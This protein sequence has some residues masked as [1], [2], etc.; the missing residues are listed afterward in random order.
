MFHEKNSK[1]R[2]LWLGLSVALAVI[3]LFGAMYW[4]PRYN[5]PTGLYWA[6]FALMAAQSYFLYK[7]DQQAQ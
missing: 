1:L 5:Q 3:T 7:E 6:I 4:G 2:R